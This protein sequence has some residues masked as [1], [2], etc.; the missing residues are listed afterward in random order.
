[1]DANQE[2][3]AEMKTTQAE[4]QARMETKTDVNLNEMTAG[5]E[6]LKEMRKP[7]KK[8]WMPR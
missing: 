3:L 1:M 8:G 4:I 2:M 5:Q 6:L 7:T